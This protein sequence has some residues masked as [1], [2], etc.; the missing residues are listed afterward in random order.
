MI[1]N[2]RRKSR[3]KHGGDQARLNIEDLDLAETTPDD[4]VLLINGALEGLECPRPGAG[5]ATGGG[6]GADE[7]VE[8]APFGAGVPEIAPPSA[9]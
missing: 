2:T 3:L 8:A 6:V 7:L 4:K 9:P 5:S 1:E